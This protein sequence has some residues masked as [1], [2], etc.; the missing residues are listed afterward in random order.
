MKNQKVWTILSAV[1]LA[2]QVIA[3]GLAMYHILRLNMLPDLYVAVLAGVFAVLT[4]VTAVV[5]F[6]HGKKPV[7]I[8]RR[9]IGMVLAL[10]IAAGCS[11][12]VYVVGQLHDTMTGITDPD[13]STTTRNVYVLREDPAQT[14]TDAKDYTFGFVLEYDTEYTGKTLELMEKELGK[15]VATQGFDTVFAMVDDL[16]SGKI[17]ALILN[18][19]Y[20]SV[21][22]EWPGYE[23]FG[24]KVR[25]LYTAE[26]EEAEPDPVPE[27]T[28]QSTQPTQPVTPL[29]ITERPFIIYLGGS[30]T[31]YK[32]LG[33]K[34]RSDVNIL[35]AVNPITK[36]IL[37][38]NTP[39]DYYVANPA[40]GGAMDKL[41][42]CGIYGTDC[43]V[44]ALENLY[45]VPVDYYAKINFTG[46][47]TLVDAIGG[48]TVYSDKS[49][50]AGAVKIQKGN[51]DL[52]GEEAL[53]FAR[54]RYHLAGG[55]NARGK[56][57]MKVIQ[58]VIQKLTSSTALISNYGDIMKSLKGMFKTD[59]PN[60][61]ISALVKQQ[62]EEMPQW[63]VLSFAVTGRTGKDKNYSMPGLKASVMYQD[64]KLVAQASD[65]LT[66]M[67]EGQTL[68][69]ADLKRS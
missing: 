55:D 24:D 44:E 51:N 53:A 9:I 1:F 65:L 16:Y 13:V 20:L 19:A 52:N 27:T 32:K 15:T 14:L 58:A 42:H 36:Q 28:E 33:N 34:T 69:E 37:L 43:S 3:E 62:L 30:D 35:A 11:V 49:F 47:E 23:D 48:V 61:D 4:A 22:E 63:E 40:G 6:V 26:L 39:R 56:N 67:L 68:T 64:E 17:G 54:E 41:T 45:G 38:L 18:D 7:S 59:I 8:C 60:E 5:L 46:F 25:V 57:Q 2:V 50:T 12:L 31:R 21:L 66:R 10:L 29:E